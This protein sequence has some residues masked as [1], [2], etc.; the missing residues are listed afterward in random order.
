MKTRLRSVF[1]VLV[2][3]ATAELAQ[4]PGTVPSAPTAPSLPTAQP[5]PVV[6]TAPGATAPALFTAEQLDQLLGP[7]ALYPDA[8]LALLLPASTNSAEVVLAARWI[9]ARRNPSDAD[10]QPW[11]DSVRA[12]V[13][14]PATLRWMD[15]NLTWT[16]QLGDTFRA[17]PDDVMA[18]VQRLRAR[19]LAAGNLFS[20]A[21]QQVVVQGNIIEILPA[22]PHTIYIPTYDARVVYLER[23]AYPPLES[24]LPYFGLGFSMGPW[25]SYGLDWPSRRIWVINRS[26]RDRHWREH[27]DAR[28]LPPPPVAFT[29][30]PGGPPPPRWHTWR[31]DPERTRHPGPPATPNPRPR[32][33]FPRNEVARPA[34]EAAST[35]PRFEK[36]PASTGPATG[37]FA[38]PAPGAPAV[39]ARAITAPPL[40]PTPPSAPPTRVRPQ[41]DSLPS[42]APVMGPSAPPA[43]TPAPVQLAPT[44]TPAPAPRQRP[45]REDRPANAE[46]RTRSSPPPAATGAPAPAP[47]PGPRAAP[48]TQPAPA[49][50]TAQPATPAESTDRRG[51]KPN[52]EAP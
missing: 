26:D 33:N 23:Y 14:Y 24:T 5:L 31:P 45:A 29:P 8:L 22:Q 2:T 10:A 13:H 43:A 18:A 11:D 30:P 41:R 37:P 42:T 50:A 25:L 21:Q 34:P 51:K 7:V 48:A 17:Q 20:N 47:T 52:P 28:P 46:P 4:P 40:A 27:R 15:D 19:A 44:P 16:I 36:P 1:G 39:N 35:Q 3:F 12:L 9:A 6:P 49:P 38:A 32:I